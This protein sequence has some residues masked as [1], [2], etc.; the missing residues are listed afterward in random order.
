MRIWAVLR[1]FL[2][3]V[4]MLLLAIAESR[5][6]AFT[7]DTRFQSQLLGV[8]D[9]FL[10]QITANISPT[11]LTNTFT[12]ELS[13]G[14]G[15][16]A[17]TL[18]SATAEGAFD[19]GSLR[20]GVLVSSTSTVTNTSGGS[21][22]YGM[23]GNAV[24]TFTDRI[25]LF[26]GTLGDIAVLHLVFDIDGSMNT[27]GGA[28][29]SL[30]LDFNDSIGGRSALSLSQ[31]SAVPDTIA[32]DMFYRFGTPGSFSLMLLASINTGISVGSSD[33]TFSRSATVDF[34]NT[35]TLMSAE[36]RDGEGNIIT[37]GAVRSVGGFSYLRSESTAVPEPST[38]VIF[39]AGL[40]IVAAR[41]R[42]RIRL[43]GPI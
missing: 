35:L 29:G 16:S 38:V 6:D 27:A 26:G 21:L 12:S 3:Q 20:L 9:S 41:L 13:D 24:S 17:T 25:T 40:F 37:D 5:G 22:N 32:F 11:S 42:K 34:L 23:G 39:G 31:S 2:S 7:M 30:R 1:L 8:V 10:Q 28:G 43:Q 15:R 33:G 36:L 18:A 14:N 4:P 19:G